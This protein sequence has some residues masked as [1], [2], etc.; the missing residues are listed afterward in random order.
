MTKSLI[1]KLRVFCD[2]NEDAAKIFNVWARL[3][4]DRYESPLRVISETSYVPYSNAVAVTK[5]LAEMEV[6]QF[7]NGRGSKETRFEF[8]C[9]R[10]ELARAAL[11]ETDKL[12]IWYDDEVEN[13]DDVDDDERAWR[14]NVI[15]SYRQTIA[16]T[17][18]ID[19]KKVKLKCEF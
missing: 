10:Q 8:W 13:E 11:G 18:D 2:E 15:K 1:K 3:K 14:K 5:A 6:G 16:I 9:S 12:E 17:F 19:I 7:W 4:A